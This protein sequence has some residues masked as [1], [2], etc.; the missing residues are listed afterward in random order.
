MAPDGSIG[1]SLWTWSGVAANGQRFA[2][3]GV[4]VSTHDENG[5]TTT[6]VVYWPCEDEQVECAIYLGTE[7]C[8]ARRIG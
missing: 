8:R 4:D 2:L 6:A 3:P 1:G 5:R 7:V